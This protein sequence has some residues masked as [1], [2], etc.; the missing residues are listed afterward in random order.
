MTL[1]ACAPDDFP[2]LSEAGIPVASD[3]E[4]AVE[5]LVDQSTNQ[6]TFNLKAQKIMP[7][8]IIDGDKYSTVNGMKRVYAKAGEYTV[9]IKIANAN[10]LSDGSIIKTFKIENSLL[11]F[12][13][14]IAFMAGTASKQWRIA[15]NEAGHIG[16]GPS[17][18]DG[19]E[20]YSASPNE[21]ADKGLYDDV[22]TFFNTK[23]YTYNPGEGG[24]VFVN[25]G[26]T[27]FSEYNTNDNNDFMAV[28]SEQSTTFDFTVEGDDLYI[29]FPTKTLFPYIANNQA[30]ENPRYKVLSMNSKKMELLSDNGEIAWHYTLTSEVD[31]TF[32]GF[33]YDSDCNVWKTATVAAPVFWY[34][35]G[36]NQ[37]ADPAY[38]LSGSTYKVILT[39]ATT[40]TWQAQMKLNSDIAT[41]TATNYDFSVILSASKNHNKV[42]VKL[43]DLNDDGN[44]YFAET[45][46]LKAYEDYI[47][48][49]SDMPG[50][51]INAIQ[52]VLDFGGNSADTEMTIRNVVLKPNSCDD[53][54]ILPSEEPEEDVTWLDEAASNLWRQA[55]FT[56]FFYYAPGW[57]QIAD[58][59]LATNNF[60][61]KL[62]LPSAT[63]DQWQA[64]T[65][66][67]TTMSTSNT[68]AYDFK[69]VLNSSQ[70]LKGVTIKLVMEGNDDVYYFAERVDLNAYED[71]TFKKVNMTGI[72]MEKVNLFFDFGGNPDNTEVTIN[73][74]V[75][76]EH[77]AGNVA[78]NADSDCNFWKTMTYTNF[79]YYAPGWNQIA[80]PAVTVNGNSYA[81]A[82]PSATSDQW[83]AQ[84]AFKTTMTTNTTNS[85]DF[86]CILN[87]NKNITGVTVKL[88]KEGDDETFYF[89]ERV[90]LIAF[91]DYKFEKVAMTGIDME[92]VN[93]F[94]DFGGNPAETEVTVSNV[95]LKESTC[96]N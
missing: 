15:K 19:L 73:G 71:F 4:N 45:I 95:I 89:A 74:I 80:D 92:K 46:E 35:P 7:V 39:E 25:A 41:N 44:Y 53:G 1:P 57:N 24:T 2:S 29:V 10:G 83:Q 84:V 3:Y 55:T 34:A 50:L 75:L 58:P 76:Q 42:T 20:W 49:K 96:N 43:V 47:F 85:Y 52:L 59:V 68:K 12:D 32:T 93:L 26:V 77:G 38:T 90:N 51:E 13:Q 31:N 23:N 48:Y 9:E 18:S 70:T 79:F 40:D 30:Y 65:A 56:N 61:Y 36:W 17:G 62:T 8:W 81:I 33:K 63:S 21:K 27:Y 66:F 22:V 72:D 6:V 94:F 5:I 11:N 60:T 91:E 67:K 88:V 69:C 37:I 28:V 78:W 87:S 54:T 64:Q 16:C 86:H 14:Y 82:L